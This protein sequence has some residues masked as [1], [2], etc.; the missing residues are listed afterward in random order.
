MDNRRLREH[1]DWPLLWTTLIITVIGL[2]NLHSATL[3]PGGEPSRLFWLQ[4]GYAAVGLV[5]LILATLLDYRILERLAYPIYALS[6]FFLLVVMAI[7][8]ARGGAQ[9]WIPLGPVNFQ[10]IEFTKLSIVI[11]LAKWFHDHP[12]LSGYRLWELFIPGLLVAVPVGLVVIQ[13]DLG[14]ALLLLM[15]MAA[16]FL[17]VRIELWTLATAGV[18][19]IIAAPLAYFFALS[20]YQ[21]ARILVFLDPEAEPRGRGYNTI[22]SKI[23]IGAGQLFGRGFNNG[24]QSKLK[25]LPAHHTDFIFSVLAEEWGFVGCISVLLLFFLLLFLGL[26]TAKRAKERFGV[27]LAFGLVAMFF[28]QIFVNVGGAIGLLPVTGVTLPFLSYGGSSLVVNFA[29]IG[30][31]LNI[32]MRRFMF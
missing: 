15:M 16:V 14:G 4:F 22:Q 30:L 3:G 32:G 13:P 26:R 6:I 10:P 29:A 31:L 12:S 23:A 11:V 20:P 28:W 8:V 7:G 25:F 2:M 24:T 27:V 18:A 1:F 5:V 9:S 17:F 19:A 21:Q